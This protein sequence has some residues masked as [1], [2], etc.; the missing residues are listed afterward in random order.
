MRM[1]SREQ[2]FDVNEPLHAAIIL[3]EARETPT[4]TAK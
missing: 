3:Q 1:S 4:Q 2:Y